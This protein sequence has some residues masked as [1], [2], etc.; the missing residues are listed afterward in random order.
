MARELQSNLKNI[1][2]GELAK[3]SSKEKR[4]YR[5]PGIRDLATIKC[6]IRETLTGTIFDCY[7]ESRIRQNL[8]TD[9]GLGKR[10]IFGITMTEVRDARF[11]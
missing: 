3:L 6:G 2:L 8:G 11:P 9:A 4:M 10:T 1:M 7:R 5:V